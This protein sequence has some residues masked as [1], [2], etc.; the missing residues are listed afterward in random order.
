MLWVAALLHPC[1]R[2]RQTPTTYA[3]AQ[4]PLDRLGVCEDQEWTRG[5]QREGKLG[6]PA[7]R[8]AA[9]GVSLDSNGR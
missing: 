2:A 1:E 9:I 4:G 5:A 8:E 3:V 7:G 6:V